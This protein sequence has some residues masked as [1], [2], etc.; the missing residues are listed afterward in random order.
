MVS[1]AKQKKGRGPKGKGKKR[2][3]RNAKLRQ[4]PRL[5]PGREEKTMRKINERRSRKER[6]RLKENN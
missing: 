4:K 1:R 6:A 3:A 2:V 5:S